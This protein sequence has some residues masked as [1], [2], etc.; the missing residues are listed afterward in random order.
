[1]F[2][3]NKLFIVYFQLLAFCFAFG[4]LVFCPWALEE[5]NSLEL[6]Y[7]SMF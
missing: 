3:V 7:Q 4:R 2:K 5:N 6:A 1:M